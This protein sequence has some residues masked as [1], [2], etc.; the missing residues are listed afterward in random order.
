MAN[1]RLYLVDTSSGEYLMIAKHSGGIWSTGNIELYQKFLRTRFSD[2]EDNTNLII[3]TENDEDF[4]NKWII[5]GDNFNERGLWGQE[6]NFHSEL[7][8]SYIT[9]KD[10]L[11]LKELFLRLSMYEFAMLCREREKEL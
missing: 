7:R 10:V 11:E 2:H 6:D 4:Y 3:G 1:N 5:R 9:K 8:K